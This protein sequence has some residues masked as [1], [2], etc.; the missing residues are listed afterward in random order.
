MPESIGDETKIQVNSDQTIDV[1]ATLT[2]F[3]EEEVG[4]ILDRFT[5][6]LTRIEVHLSDIDNRKTGKADKRCFIEV[7]PQG[8]RPLSA[9][10]K[11]TA[12]EASVREAAGKMQ[13]SL[14]AFFGRKGRPVA[15]AKA[16]EPQTGNAVAKKSSPP[17]GKNPGAKIA[18]KK[19]TVTKSPAE[20]M[21]GATPSK[22]H[23]RG[24]KKKGIY[25]ARRKSLPTR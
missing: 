1:D 25:Q 7:R 24:P 10:A 4:R 12:T 19:S 14:T 11:T 6:R 8:H 2:S 15:L 5:K 17:T 21:A 9:T 13:R 18:A 16:A 22:L 23:P 20:K 3:I